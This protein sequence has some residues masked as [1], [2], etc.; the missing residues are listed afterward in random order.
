MRCRVSERRKRCGNRAPLSQTDAQ[1]L[2]G[3]SEL[4]DESAQ[5]KPIEISRGDLQRRFALAGS[6]LA[7]YRRAKQKSLFPFSIREQQVAEGK[8]PSPRTRGTDPPR[9]RS[10]PSLTPLD[11]GDIFNGAAR[12]GA[13]GQAALGQLEESSRG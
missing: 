13:R 12:R 4:S 7:C 6:S 10:S 11:G 2:Q 5:A 1:R 8:N 3:V 9:S